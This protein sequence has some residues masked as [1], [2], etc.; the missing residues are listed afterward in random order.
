MRAHSVSHNRLTGVATVAS[1]ESRANVCQIR[2]GKSI[3]FVFQQI[4][5]SHLNTLI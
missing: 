2:H 1:R 3:T 4:N 5:N